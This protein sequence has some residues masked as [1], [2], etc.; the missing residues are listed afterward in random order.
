MKENVHEFR[1][2]ISTEML[3]GSQVELGKQLEQQ[4]NM[5]IA[6]GGSLR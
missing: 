3:K 6:R 2:F 1:K 5:D 4:F